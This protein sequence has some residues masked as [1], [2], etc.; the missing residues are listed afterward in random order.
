VRL[1]NESEL[2]ELARGGDVGAYEVLM[3]EHE[4]LAYRIAY[5]Y[6][7]DRGDAE[8][9]VQDAF[10]KAYRALSRF[11]HGAPFR[12]WL[13]RIVINEAKTRRRASR[14]REALDGVLRQVVSRDAAV[15]S[16]E[17]KLLRADDR[18]TLVGALDR[19]TLKLRDVVVCRYLVELSEEETAVALAIPVGTVK[20][21]LSRALEKLSADQAL[22]A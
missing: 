9:A 22:A 6:T 17:A 20:S 11:R 2:V 19:L 7:R 12:P 13:L 1:R 21:R 15:A 16:A 10:L 5:T 18:Q 8:E 4:R 3:R 14:R